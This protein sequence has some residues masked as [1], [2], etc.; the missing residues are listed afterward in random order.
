MDKLAAL[1]CH[2]LGH[3][4]HC[5]AID[6]L[7]DALILFRLVHGGISSSINQDVWRCVSQQVTKHSG[8][9]EVT[10]VHINGVRS[11]IAGGG[12]L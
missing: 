7:S 1:L 5:I 4:G 12:A 2:G 3:N 10:I 6:R 9:G 11:H 8:I